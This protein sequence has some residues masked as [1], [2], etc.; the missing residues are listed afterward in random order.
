MWK[1]ITECIWLLDL[2]LI[3]S[4]NRYPCEN[5]SRPRGWP[6]LIRPSRSIYNMPDIKLSL[7]FTIANMRQLCSFVCFSFFNIIILDRL[8]TEV[9]GRG[10]ITAVVSHDLQKSM[11]WRKATFYTQASVIVMGLSWMANRAERSI[12]MLATN[13]D[14][15]ASFF[16]S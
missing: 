11:A 8:G 7:A 15:S 13:C 4:I 16:A 10:V 6:K 1:L 9:F 5:N 2:D 3:D 14:Q 12:V